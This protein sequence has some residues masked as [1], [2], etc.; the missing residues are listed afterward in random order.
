MYIKHTLRLSVL[1]LTMVSFLPSTSA[2]AGSNM[3]ITPAEDHTLPTSVSPGQT[4]SAYYTV[5][6]N[7]HSI[8][9]GYKVQG[10]PSSVKQ[11]TSGTLSCANPITLA[12]DGSCTL[13]LDITSAVKYLQRL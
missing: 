9:S 8:R 1:S 10:L 2:Y 6:N 13:Q 12:A 7:T 11:N 4:V 5:I 3:L